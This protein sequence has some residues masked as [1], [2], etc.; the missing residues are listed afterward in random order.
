MAVLAR[1]SGLQRMIRD[2]GAKD[3]QQLEGQLTIHQQDVQEAFRRIGGNV[4]PRLEQRAGTGPVHLQEGELFIADT[5]TGDTL[6]TLPEAT[7]QNIGAICAVA[8][9]RPQ[10]A[11]RVFTRG[12]IDTVRR[13]ADPLRL[14]PVGAWLFVATT[15]GWWS[16]GQRS[17]YY[18]VDGARFESGTDAGSVDL[19][20]AREGRIVTLS[21]EVT[22]DGGSGNSITSATGWLPAW[23]RPAFRTSSWCDILTSD[24]SAFLLQVTPA[25]T[26]IFLKRDLSS[27]IA[28]ADWSAETRN[29]QLSYVAAT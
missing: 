28:A 22:A 7:G 18:A 19:R 26:V 11:V 20:V 5:L 16:L 4:W 6:V 25:G 12:R 21:A 17:E 2:W 15:D 23:A 29:F 14:T 27:G 9:A 13:H 8:K 10:N 24:N 1:L 3:P